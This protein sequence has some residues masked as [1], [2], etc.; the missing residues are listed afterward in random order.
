[1]WP[2]RRLDPLEQLSA[3]QRGGCQAID[4]V[5]CGANWGSNPPFAQQHGSGDPAFEEKLPLLHRIEFH[6]TETEARTAL[7]LVVRAER[8]DGRL[9]SVFSKPGFTG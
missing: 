5:E 2:D 8:G 1:M 9:E 4:A 3:S 6:C 7:R